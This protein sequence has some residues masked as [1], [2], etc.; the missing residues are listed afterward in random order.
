MR[1]QVNQAEHESRQEAEHRNALQNVEH[2]QHH[3]FRTGHPRHR[4]AI[5]HREQE[6]QAVSQDATRQ[7]EQRVERQVTRLQMNFRDLLERCAPLASHRD[8]CIDERGQQSDD[9]QINPAEGARCADE[10][11]VRNHS[12][13]RLLT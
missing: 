1:K 12:G 3:P 10:L 13:S 4:V 2:R 5:D 9:G 7:A 6:R 11:F 8:K